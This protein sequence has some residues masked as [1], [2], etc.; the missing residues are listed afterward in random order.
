[1]L[2]NRAIHALLR[3]PNRLRGGLNGL[4]YC[5]IILLLAGCAT[6]TTNGYSRL[7]DQ[8]TEWLEHNV[9]RVSLPMGGGSGFWFNDKFITACHLAEKY[10]IAYIYNTGRKQLTLAEV[11]F[12]DPVADIAIL[13]PIYSPNNRGSGFSSIPVKLADEMPPP[14]TLI[15]SAGWESGGPL[16]FSYGVL[17]NKSDYGYEA[18]MHMVYGDSGGPVLCLYDDQ[19]ELIGMNVSFTIIRQETKDIHVFGSSTMVGVE[20]LRT[21]LAEYQKDLKGL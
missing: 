13:K 17:N 14:G 21:A 2:N 15:W 8:V 19:I 1:M 18:A 12:C 10:P 5:L 7:P 6:T 9:W 16:G 3:L 20:T 4:S 11:S